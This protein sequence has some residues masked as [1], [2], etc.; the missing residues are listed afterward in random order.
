MNVTSS[1]NKAGGSAGIVG[2]LFLLISTI[3]FMPSSLHGGDV[4][5]SRE[6]DELVKP[7]IDGHWVKGMVVGL[8]NERDRQVIGYGSKSDQDETAPDGQ[9]VFEIGS[10]TKTFTAT[11]LADAVVR[12]Q[13]ELSDPVKKFL[14]PDVTAPTGADGR[15]ITLLDL[16]THSSGLPR[17]PSN[18]APADP[19]NPYA[20]YTL[21]QMYDYLAILKLDREP[22]EK[23]VYSNLGVALL[24]NALALHARLSYED[25]LLDRICRPLKMSSTRIMFDDSMRSRLAP[26]Y[27]PDGNRLETWDLPTFA[28]AGGIRSTADD[29]LRYLGAE[30]GLVKTDLTAALELSQK[31]RRTFSRDNDICLGW[32]IDKKTGY[33]YH[34]GQTGGY[35]SFAAFDPAKRL[36]VVVLANTAGGIP[37]LIGSRIVRRL[38]GQRVAPPPLPQTI[39]VK[40]DVIQRYAGEYKL[41]ALAWCTIKQVG[42]HLTARLTGQSSLRIYPES[43]TTFFYKAVN[44]KIT[45]ETDADGNTTALVLH[46]NGQDKRA[47]KTK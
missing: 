2:A 37:D 38:Y 12:G 25:L 35:H 33:H 20:D 8:I 4:L 46:Q 13:L 26:P 34:N 39:A 43:R 6:I 5:A 19:G 30:I 44:A 27:D 41:G 36:G 47:K 7:A 15:P 45:F 40:S 3:T 42:D 31:P 16:T 18:F 1:N 32:F 9:S 14:P 21:K 17:M 23:C 29:M 22:G 28:G 10:I 24:G 11:L